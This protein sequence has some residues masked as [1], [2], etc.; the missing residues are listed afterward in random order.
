MT[1]L[2]CIAGL[3][4]FVGLA[5]MLCENRQQVKITTIAVGMGVQL[6]LALMFLKIPMLSQG[7]VLLN[8]VVLAL[9]QAT[10]AGTSMVF[11]YLGGRPFAL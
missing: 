11:G 7:F 5:W 2:Q 3:A 1:T 9:E 8:Q 4:V 10:R 6:L